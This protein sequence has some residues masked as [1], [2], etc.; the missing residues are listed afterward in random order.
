MTVFG[1]SMSNRNIY[2]YRV[3]SLYVDLFEFMY[4]TMYYYVYFY[5]EVIQEVLIKNVS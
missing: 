2:M 5:K 3:F 4:G 1:L